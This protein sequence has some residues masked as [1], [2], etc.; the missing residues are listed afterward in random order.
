MVH[1]I[2]NVSPKVDLAKKPS[3]QSPGGAWPLEID[4]VENWAWLNDLFSPAE[5]QTIINIGNSTELERAHTFGPDDP[6]VRD[7]FV[8]FLFPNEIT[9]WIFQRLTTAINGINDQFFKFDIH[10][11]EQGLQFTK[12]SAP[13]QHYEW[14]VDRGMNVG[15]RKLSLSLQ[16]SDSDD[17]EGGDLELWYGGD[18]VKASRVKGNI[19]FFPAYTMHRVTPVTKGTRYS[20]VCWVSGP[21]FK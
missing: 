21:P 7:S 17:Y 6:K 2:D 15:T 14:H 19:T 18:P 12:Y 10:S 13:G 8:H 4:H 3:I 11:M 5:L 1:L 16:L 9:T 20:L